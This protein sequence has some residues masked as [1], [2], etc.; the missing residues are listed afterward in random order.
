MQSVLTERTP[1]PGVAAAI[2]RAEVPMSIIITLVVGLVAGPTGEP[3]EPFEAV[4]D[5]GEFPT[6][7]DQGREQSPAFPAPATT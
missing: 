2:G 1:G 5:Q 3:T 6:L 4:T 7:T